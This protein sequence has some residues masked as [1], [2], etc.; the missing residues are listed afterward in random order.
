[1]SGVLRIPPM[2]LS[3]WVLRTNQPDANPMPS[4]NL[5][6]G[7]N[8]TPATPLKASSKRVSNDGILSLWDTATGKEVH[9]L[10]GVAG[11]WLATLPVS[12]FRFVL[13]EFE[14][15]CQSAA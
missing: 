13:P 5:T 7:T 15:R 1:M 14:N 4:A 2:E 12:G 6:N 3:L 11:G 8:Q 9:R 10:Q